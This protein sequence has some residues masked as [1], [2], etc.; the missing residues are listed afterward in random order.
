MSTLYVLLPYL[1]AVF[2]AATAVVLFTGLFS[3]ATDNKV[4]HD[5]SNLMMRWRVG[6][7]GMTIALIGLYFLTIA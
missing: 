5:Q 3:M 1:I 7:Q 4:E 2:A 6:L